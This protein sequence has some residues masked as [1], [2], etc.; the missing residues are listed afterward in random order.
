MT[1]GL[2]LRFALRDLRSGLQG[3]WIFL[4]CLALGT[5]AIAII[6]SLAAAV[7]RG[8]D[9]Q[10][11]PLL[12]GD[13]EFSLIHREASPAERSFI[14]SKGT[15]SRAA[16]LRAMAVT[17]LATTL[18]EV[19]SVDGNYPLYGAL[20]LAEGSD[21]N[22]ALEFRNGVHGAVADPLLMRRLGIKVGERIKIGSVEIA[23]RGL[24]TS[25]PDRISDGI[26]LGPRLLM[27]E[28]GLQATG[29]IQPGSLITWRYRVKLAGA[30]DT[31]AVNAVIAEAKEKF[32]D[33]GWRV[34]NRNNAAQG[35]DRFVERLG[36]FMTLVGL[37]S[38]IV[39]G[40]GIA[41]AV[42]AFVSRKTSSIATLK[43]LGATSRHVFGI[44][45]TEIMLVALIA[46]TLGLAAG[47]VAPRLA[48][49][50]L[51]DL[52]PLPIAAHIEVQPLL[53]AGLLGLLVTMAF[54][55]WPLGRTRHVPASA[56]FRHRALPVHGRPS[57]GDVVCI[58]VALGAIAAVVFMNFDEPVITGYYL[59]GLT[60]SFV[61]LLALARFIVWGAQRLPRVPSAI[62]RYAVANIHRPGSASTS[63]IMAL[64]LGL[65][66]F[67]TLALTD[68][69]ISA[70]LKS[71]IPE[72]APAFFF[73]DVRN[74]ELA[75]FTDAVKEEQG[76]TEVTAAPMLRGRMVSIKGIPVEKLEA[77]PDTNW[78]LRGD[79][80][81]TYSDRLPEG[82]RLV[83]G[84][85]WP[86]NY[87]GPPLVSMVGEIADGIGVRIGDEIT[88]NVLGRE[89]SAKVANFREV[90]WRSLGINFVMVFSPNTLKAAPHSHIVTVE[91][92]GGDEAALLNSMARAFPSV[93][94]VR[95]KEAIT[96]VSD[97]LGKMLTAIRSANVLTLLTGVLVLAGALAAGLSDRLYDTV[98]L[99]TYGASRAQ[100]IGAFVIEYASLGL[101]AAAF[102]LLVG[103]LASWFLA[104]FILE[105]PWSFSAATA[106]LTAV[107]A[108]AVAVAAGLTVTWSALSARPAP[109]LRNE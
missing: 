68:R 73:L 81:L 100:L 26:I 74:D 109:Y 54:A 18:V 37:A 19:K 99:K 90:N 16:T 86:T 40:A 27:S 3:V 42:A 96:I 66:L 39:G 14:T 43:C 93:T 98:V 46:I 48:K 50:A 65:T 44:Y 45:L 10:G 49:A 35:A 83:E 7:E 55:L 47:A 82:S 9:E 6:G 58:A 107:I 77:T 33:A 31:T 24:V 80:G 59:G 1:P 97:L 38:L 5:A 61:A 4:S 36:Y 102:G 88:V 70:E 34:R 78:A 91:M 67:V 2:W 105:M 53:V 85:W 89:V 21:L 52:I 108:M 51:S 106:V 17:G 95:V 25:E 15:V 87:E 28:A 20:Q 94:A 69:T 12:G 72:K 11:Q 22:T 71:S 62:W 41:N 79:R 63:V 29:L 32:P 13:I 75:A 103:S 64:G 92:E 57:R 84:E 101:A 30:T 8:I 56:L 104:R 23:I 60:A 76:V